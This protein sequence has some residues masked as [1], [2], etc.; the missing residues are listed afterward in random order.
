MTSRPKVLMFIDWYLPGYKAGGPIRS[1]A[2]LVAHL[3]DEVDFYIV[4]GDRDYQSHEAYPGV[5]FNQWVDGKNGEKIYYTSRGKLDKMRVLSLYRSQDFSSVY[6]H[7]IFSRLFSILPLR[8]I[9]GIDVRLVISPRGMLR[10][11]AISIKGLKKKAYLMLALS[12]GWFKGVKFHVTDEQEILDVQEW[13]GEDVETHLAPNL[14]VMGNAE[15]S[16]LKKEVGQLNLIFAGR[17]APEKNLLYAIEVLSELKLGKVHLDIY[18]A[19]YSEEYKRQCIALIEQLP[20]NVSAEFKGSVPSKEL[21]GVL[22]QHHA[23]FLPTRGENFG[24]II[25]ETFMVSRPVIISDQT[26]WIGLRDE[27]VG[28]ELPL[29]SQDLFIKAIESYVMMDQMTYDSLC[30]N[31]L[32]KYQSFS[33]NPELIAASKAIFLPRD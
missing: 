13:I 5:P 20:E 2:N 10:N 31:A 11:S 21:L 27:G 6:I 18:G 29:T 19:D 3:S 24:H 23:L 28:I 16:L 7:G 15:L 1:C 14:P 33:Q 17:I 22:K 4:T 25:L 32:S 9:Q 26:P 30:R 8:A 12:M